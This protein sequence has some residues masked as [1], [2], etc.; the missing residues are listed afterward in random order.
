MEAKCIL[1]KG[2]YQFIG[3]PETLLEVLTKFEK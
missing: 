3:L 1:I 2:F